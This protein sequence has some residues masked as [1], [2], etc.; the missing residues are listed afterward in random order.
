MSLFDIRIKYAEGKITLQELIKLK[1][2][3]ITFCTRGKSS[4]ISSF[5]ISIV[6]T[7]DIMFTKTNKKRVE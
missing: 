1:Q 7:Y 2:C 6:R 5:F 3:Q 4:F